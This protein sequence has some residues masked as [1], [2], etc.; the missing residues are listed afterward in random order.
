MY[1]H[2]NP[3]KKITLDFI[4]QLHGNIL[5]LLIIPTLYCNLLP[6]PIVLALCLNI[7]PLLDKRIFVCLFSILLCPVSYAFR[8]ILNHLALFQTFSVDYCICYQ[9]G[10]IEHSRASWKWGKVVFLAL[11]KHYKTWFWTSTLSSATMRHFI[12]KCI[13]QQNINGQMIFKIAP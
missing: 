12:R 7:L 8:A 11:I 3:K 4:L 13:L 2:Y 10:Y 1:L 6:L 5:S 9:G